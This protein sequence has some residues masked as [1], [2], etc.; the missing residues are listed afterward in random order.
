MLKF[1]SVI[2]F[3]AIFS[4]ISPFEGEQPYLANI[5]QLTFEDMGLLK[6]G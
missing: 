2:G 5:T 3:I 6:A 1:T 4:A